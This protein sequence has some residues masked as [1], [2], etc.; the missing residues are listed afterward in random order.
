MTDLKREVARFKDTE[1]YSGKYISDLEARLARADESV[2]ALQQTVEKLESE[3]R[4]QERRSRGA[5]NSFGESQVRW[6]KL[7]E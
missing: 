3:M 4:S 2:I 5:A 7:E 6:F 1:S